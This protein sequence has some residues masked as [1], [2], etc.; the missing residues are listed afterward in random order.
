[1]PKLAHFGNHSL[2][3]MA[4]FDMQIQPKL[5]ETALLFYRVTDVPKNGPVTNEPKLV[6]RIDLE[7]NIALASI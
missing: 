7:E 2:L 4:R 5:A 6:L 3:I 1:M